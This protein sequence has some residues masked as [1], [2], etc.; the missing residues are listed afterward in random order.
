MGPQGHS[1]RVRGH[2]GTRGT[3]LLPV[4]PP[5][6]I[7][8]YHPQLMSLKGG[9]RAGQ[10]FT[11]DFSWGPWVR[12]PPESH[13]SG[14]W[15]TLHPNPAGG[16]WGWQAPQRHCAP[17]PTPYTEPPRVLLEVPGTQDLG[18]FIPQPG[19]PLEACVHRVGLRYLPRELG[20]PASLPKPCPAGAT[21]NP[22]LSC[23]TTARGPFQ[24]QPPPRYGGEAPILAAPSPRPGSRLGSRAT[25]AA[26]IQAL[27]QASAGAQ[28]WGWVPCPRGPWWKTVDSA[29]GLLQTPSSA[30]CQHLS[31]EADALPGQPWRL[32]G[33]LPI[34][35]ASTRPHSRV[36]ETG[37][38]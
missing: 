5:L 32:R 14:F 24:N 27:A 29:R 2:S 17:L 4:A 35:A 3:W 16:S 38:P 22:A 7:R 34:Q 37:G 25:P 31:W 8:G 30:F 20:G 15:G 28:A 33:L 26:T 1:G 11:P 23:C 13:P 6:S 36:P 12:P 19:N 10:G 18:G 9:L 21:P